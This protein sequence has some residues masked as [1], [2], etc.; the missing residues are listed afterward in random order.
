M[1]RAIIPGPLGTDTRQTTFAPGSERPGIALEEGL[2]PR[3]FPSLIRDT[4]QPVDLKHGPL[5]EALQWEG[6]AIR[7]DTPMN[8]ARKLTDGEIALCMRLFKSS[9]D[10][11]KVLVHRKEFLPFGLQPDDCAMTPNGELYFNPMKFREDFSTEDASQQWWFMH[12]MVHVW[13]RHLGYWVMLRGAVRIGL[14]YAYELKPG[15]KLS[16][17]NMEAQGNLL[18]DFFALKHLGRPDVMAQYEAYGDALPLFEEILSAF[19]KNPSDRSHL[20]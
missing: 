1:V 13:Q 17:Y 3:V 4:V 14:S 6:S 19:Q 15:R 10:Y 2:G 9:I 11:S 7:R 20:P 5:T 8:G 18:A 16:D 12:E